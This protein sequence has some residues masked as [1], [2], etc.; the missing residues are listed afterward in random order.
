MPRRSPR[1]ATGARPCYTTAHPARRCLAGCKPSSP[2]L[3]AS[4]R[5]PWRSP[6]TRAGSARPCLPAG[7]PP[8]PPPPPRPLRTPPQR[9]GAVR[10]DLEVTDL[11]ALATAIA[12]TADTRR[13]DRLLD[14]VRRGTDPNPARRAP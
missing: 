3:P 5:W 10:A 2:T 14:L 6:T 7:T 11:L 4:G 1:C 13:T 9:A 8:P 12:L